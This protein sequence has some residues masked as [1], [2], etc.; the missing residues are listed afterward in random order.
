MTDYSGYYIKDL[1][2]AIE[3][4]CQKIGEKRDY[5]KYLLSMEQAESVEKLIEIYDNI[6]KLLFVFTYG[7]TFP[8]D[9]YK[10]ESGGYH[11]QHLVELLNRYFNDNIERLSKESGYLSREMLAFF[12]ANLREC[13]NAG[14]V[15]SKMMEKRLDE[16]KAVFLEIGN[17]G[18]TQYR[19]R[20]GIES[21]SKMDRR[22]EPAI[23]IYN[24]FS[25]LLALKGRIFDVSEIAFAKDN[26]IDYNISLVSR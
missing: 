20:K 4:G 25:T 5:V 24:R 23:K 11:K 17:A 18:K 3:E 1:L 2:E 8:H 21:M 22:Y 14:I 26:G 19:A 12:I 16:E 10:P 15:Q 7:Y 13:I 6:Y 9:W